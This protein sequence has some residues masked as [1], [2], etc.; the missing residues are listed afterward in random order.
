ML[1]FPA[2]VHDARIFRMTV[3]PMTTTRTRQVLTVSLRQRDQ[4][5]NCHAPDYSQGVRRHVFPDPLPTAHEGGTVNSPRRSPG[6]KM[7]PPSNLKE[8]DKRRAN[9][10][11]KSWRFEATF[12]GC[13]VALSGLRDVGVCSPRT[14]PWALEGDPFGVAAKPLRMC[15][16]PVPWAHLLFPS[17]ARPPRAARRCGLVSLSSQSLDAAKTLWGTRDFARRTWSL[18]SSSSDDA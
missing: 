1:G 4:L 17:V 10:A 2:T 12:P 16:P 9:V 3:L 5:A 6:M 18:R 8:R 14:A 13:Y 7:F 11:I 15:V